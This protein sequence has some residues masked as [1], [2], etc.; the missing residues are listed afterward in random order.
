MDLKA[1]RLDTVGWGAFVVLF[2]SA[3]LLQPPH[4]ASAQEREEE[5]A[6]PTPEAPTTAAPT[7]EATPQV[8]EAVEQAEAAVEVGIPADFTI[9]F[10]DTDDW[11]QFKA[12]EWLKGEL[13]WMRQTDNEMEFESKKLKLMQFKWS[14]IVQLHAARIKTYV[15]EKGIVVTGRAMVTKE[16]VIIE[17]VEGVK[18][19]PRDKLVSIIRG[20]PRERNYWSTRLRAGFSGNAGNSE[21]ISLNAFWRLKRGDELSRTLISYEGTFAS[22]AREETANRHL[23]DAS[24][25]LFISRRVFITPIKGQ[26]LN[27]RFQNLRLRATP[28]AGAGVHIFD[29]K[30][31]WD[32][33]GSLGYQF[34]NFL[35]TAAGIK[36]PQ[37]DGLFAAHTYFKWTFVPD[38]NLELDWLT[39][40]VYTTIGLTNHIGS[41]KLKLK[42]VSI[43]EFE[44]VFT[45][46][47]TERPPPRADGTVP[48]RNDYQVVIGLV[49]KINE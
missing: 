26:L 21:Q 30:V 31:K 45:F 43:F 16:Q 18:V 4:G 32:V 36:N 5:P 47:R 1:S 11:I 6:K 3:P 48:K 39:N 19:F 24:L 8:Q 13:K 12:G 42:V 49:L 25:T 40:V 35:S 34:T 41:A 29:T 10:G 15:F 7:E 28:T 46:F 20:E 14:D 33:D 9:E 38:N 27:D 17:T 37:H 2:L 23:G 44:T 22:A